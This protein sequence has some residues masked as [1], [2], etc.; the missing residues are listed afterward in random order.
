MKTMEDIFNGKAKDFYFIGE[1]LQQ[2]REELI[3]KDPIEDKRQSQF[4][5]KAMAERLGVDYQTITN[6]E[7]GPLSFNT[8]KLLLYY[9]SLGYNPIWVMSPDNEFIP[10]MN[11]GANLVYQDDVQQ[12][13]KDLEES[14]VLALTEFKKNI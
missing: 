4:S 3:A 8:I 2:I 11:V 1:R 10:K 13:Y 5:R 6:I 12:H 14:I 7:R 9:Y